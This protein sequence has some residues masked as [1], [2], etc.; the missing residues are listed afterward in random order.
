LGHGI[1]V[2]VP[3]FED[4]ESYVL[5]HPIQSTVRVSLVAYAEAVQSR[6]AMEHHLPALQARH[7]A[8]Y[9]ARGL[10]HYRGRLLVW[11]SGD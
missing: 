11:T 9:G 8:S 5:S 6:E 3:S 2:V 10:T 7:V 1:A 4:F